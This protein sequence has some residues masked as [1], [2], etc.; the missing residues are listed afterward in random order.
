MRA[1]QLTE[2]VNHHGEGPVWSPRWA[3]VRWVDMLAGE[4]CELT[5]DGRVA[6]RHVGD[7]AAM[8]R[9]RSGGGFVVATERGVA[10]ADSDAL[11]APLQHLP[12]LLDD[13]AVRMNEGGCAPDGTL[14]LGS[15][16][17]NSATGGGTLYRVWPD[18]AHQVID[19]AVTISNGIDWS[20]DGRTCYYVDTPTGRID[21]FDWTPDGLSGRRPLTE[22]EGEGAP[23]G[24]TV[25]AD[26]RI[27]VAVFGG[28]QVR[29][30]STDGRLE[31][32]VDVPA[33]QVTAV[34][35][36]GAELDEL[37]ITTSRHGLDGAAEPAAGALFRALT[38]VRGQRVRTFGVPQTP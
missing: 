38:G 36:A 27:W 14:Y 26:G 10:L 5:P 16:A 11:H 13:S 37:V 28:G 3:G 7:V 6:R 35:F 30:Y 24:L 21:Q 8:V 4:V 15:M 23:D 22:M 17:Y 33:L 19:P 32:V 2:A 34:T 31:E 29:C 1:E 25:D 9:P 20:P 12:D 18:G